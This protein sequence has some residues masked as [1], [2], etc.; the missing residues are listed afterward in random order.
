MAEGVDQ[1]LNVGAWK[2][3]TRVFPV[4]A[5][6][7][8]KIKPHFGMGLP[9]YFFLA[10]IPQHRASQVSVRQAQMQSTEVGRKSGNMRI[11]GSRILAETRVAELTSRPSSIKRM[12]KQIE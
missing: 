6:T 11:V 1:F 3:V 12:P 2:G 8:G 9:V 5:Q 7:F 4:P 10:E